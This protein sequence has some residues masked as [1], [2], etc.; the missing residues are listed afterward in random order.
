MSFSSRI[1]RFW[2]QIRVRLGFYLNC[3]FDWRHGVDTCGQHS[4]TELGFNDSI[5]RRVY[6][7]SSTP[8]RAIRVVLEHLPID[9]S[10]WSF[11]DVGCGKGRVLLIAMN[12]PFRRII[13]IEHAV[14]LAQICRENIS[15][16]SGPRHCF[17]IDVLTEDA[18]A[19]SPP[20]DE[21]FFV[22]LF[23]PFTPE[24]LALFLNRLTV[25]P[26]A[27]G[28]QRLICFLQQRTPLAQ[29]VDPA[30]LCPSLKPVEFATLGF[31]WLSHPQLEVSL[32][33][34]H[35]SM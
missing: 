11:I 19:F 26:L 5:A 25:T 35:A 10:D 28:K 31:D 29:K 17:N 4:V 2:L 15:N 8:H 32:F 14:S 6:G 1:E 21:N 16:Y 33:D 23:N 34:A 22:Y 20:E 24:L 12:H 9:Y 30:I 7:F 27:T 18:M 13:G 3:F